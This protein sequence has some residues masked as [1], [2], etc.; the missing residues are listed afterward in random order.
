MREERQSVVV[1][2]LAARKSAGKGGGNYIPFLL[3]R[4]SRTWNQLTEM[5]KKM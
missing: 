1:A 4:G 5:D 2:A 3:M